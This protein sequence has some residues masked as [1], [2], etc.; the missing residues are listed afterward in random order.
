MNTMRPLGSAVVMVA[1]AL[2][3][4]A[5]LYAATDTTIKGTTADSTQVSL[6]VTNSSNTQLLS[7][8]NDGN[9]GIGQGAPTAFLHLKAGV[10]TANVGAPIK[11]T[12]GTNLTTAEAGA[13]EYDGKVF[14]ST[15][16]ASARGISPS[17]MYSIVP[18]GGFALSTAAGVQSCFPTSGDVWT[19][20]GTTTYAFEGFYHIQ[21]ATNSVS[22]AM[23]FA[24]G[25]SIT[26]IKYTAWAQNVAV[27]TTGATVAAT[28]V[29]RVA[30]TIVNAAS[31]AHTQIHFSGIIRTNAAGTVT[32]QIDFSGTAAGTPTMMQDSY[33]M[34]TPIGTNTQNTVGNVA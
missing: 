16:V 22:V 4:T 15:P 23:A 20:A 30:T 2:M 33:I 1:G 34:F 24:L 31:T 25:G 18:S 14:Y 29:D 19:L 6:D 32:P 13:V 5:N 10:A 27:N 12:S 17:T 21:K 3:L 9:I 11:L 7:V 28:Y 26:S 8:R